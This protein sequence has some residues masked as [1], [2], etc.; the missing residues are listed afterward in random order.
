MAGARSAL[1]LGYTAFEHQ[2]AAIEQ[3]LHEAPVFVP[4]LAKSIIE[5]SCKTILKDRGVDYS[6]GADLPKLV[7]EVQKSILSDSVG[8]ESTQETREALTKTVNGLSAAISGLCQLRNQSGLLGHGRDASAGGVVAHEALLAARAADAIVDF[9]FSMHRDV[10]RRSGLVRLEYDDT[11]DFNQFIDG[12]YP[13]MEV[14]Q[15]R[16]TASEVLFALDNQAYAAARLEFIT[17][18]QADDGVAE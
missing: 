8:L 16:F 14:L 3:S 2:I 18:Q 6:P 7:R 17:A 9:L 12:L 4:D 13:G 1:R 10:S 11:P 15:S 5:T